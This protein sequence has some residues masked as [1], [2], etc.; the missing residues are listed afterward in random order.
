MDLIIK[1]KHAQLWSTY[2]NI[3]KEMLPVLAKNMKKEAELQMHK[4]LT[5][6]GIN[7]YTVV[8]SVYK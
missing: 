7:C 5:K 1:S 3:F 6:C 2:T 8:V 4:L